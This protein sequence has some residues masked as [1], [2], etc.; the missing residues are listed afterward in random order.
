M[1]VESLVGPVTYSKQGAQALNLGRGAREEV[2]EPRIG[3]PDLSVACQDVG[4]IVGRIEGHCQNQIPGW[5]KAL[6]EL[7]KVVG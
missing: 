5:R 4:S 1:G 6:L 3:F 2:P 7:S